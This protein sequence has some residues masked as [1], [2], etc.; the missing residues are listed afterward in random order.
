MKHHL[1][2]NT[3]VSNIPSAV[4]DAVNYP[5]SRY[6]RSRH[7]RGARLTAGAL[8]TYVHK[9]AAHVGAPLG[10]QTNMGMNFHILR[11]TPRAGKSKA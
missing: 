11:V 9:D 4:T 1:H 7:T 10:E 2:R 5:R 6:P 8:W 3:P